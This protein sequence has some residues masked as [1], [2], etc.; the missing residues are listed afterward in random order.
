[1]SYKQSPSIIA[2]Q[3][4]S[5]VQS[6]KINIWIAVTICFTFSVGKWFNYIIIF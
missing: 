3:K 5:Y 6:M 1:M 2:F 4:K